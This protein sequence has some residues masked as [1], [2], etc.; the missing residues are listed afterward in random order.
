[1][2]SVDYSNMYVYSFIDDKG[3]FCGSIPAGEHAIDEFFRT[4]N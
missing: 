1:M 4:T 3:L 2:L